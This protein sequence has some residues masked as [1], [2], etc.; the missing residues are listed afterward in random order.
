[1]T[2]PGSD[3][4]IGKRSP[5]GGNEAPARRAH[6]FL[7]G[8]GGL[9]IAIGALAFCLDLAPASRANANDA[10]VAYHDGRVSVAAREVPAEDILREIASQAGASLR[11]RANGRRVITI[12]F[13]DVTVAEALRRIL[14]PANF[15]LLYGPEGLRVV[16][17]LQ[18]A[19]APIAEAAGTSPAPTSPEPFPALLATRPPQ[20]ID[21]LLAGALGHDAATYPQLLDAALHHPDREMRARAVDTWVTGVEADPELHTALLATVDAMPASALATVV[22]RTAGPRGAELFEQVAAR[23]SSP[24]LVAVALAV[25][26]ELRTG[27]P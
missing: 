18:G 21:A 25:L 3:A 1:V 5:K 4:G 20:S 6:R 22:G 23:T 14:R 11:G 16:E 12:D 15:L 19:E 17:L 27:D 10:A 8:C 13:A 26:S 7:R 9:S 24:E 2:L